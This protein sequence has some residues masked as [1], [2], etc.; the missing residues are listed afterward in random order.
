MVVASEAVGPTDCNGL[1]GPARHHEARPSHADMWMS[2]L[3]TNK[4]QVRPLL[5]QLAM[6]L[7]IIADHLDDRDAVRQLLDEAVRAKSSCL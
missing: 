5:K 6:R 2:I 4:D 7:D 1:V 3:A